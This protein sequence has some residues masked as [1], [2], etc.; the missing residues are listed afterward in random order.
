MITRK[1]KLKLNKADSAKAEGLLFQLT[2][3]V[4]WALRKLEQDAEGGVFHRYEDLANLT[5]GQAKKSGIHSPSRSLN[6][7]LA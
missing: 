7:L 2:G 3:A 6:V 1:L 5:S 4:N